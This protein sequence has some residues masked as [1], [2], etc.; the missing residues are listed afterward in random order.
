MFDVGP[1][2]LLV[3]LVV[4]VLVIGPE[5]LPR[6]ARDAARL[7]RSLREMAGTAREQ[8]RTE[9]GPELGDLDLRSL[10]PRTAIRRLFDE[11][12]PEPSE[13][14]AP[15]PAAPVAIAS[16]PAA[17]AAAAYDEAT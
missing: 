13:P 2:E 10:H 1:M 12:E 5:R 16:E 7:L 11:P 15:E 14:V 4:G 6:L 17:P 9:L 3:L 8:V